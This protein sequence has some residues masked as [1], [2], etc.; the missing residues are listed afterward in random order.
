[1]S[2]DWF[3][4]RDHGEEKAVGHSEY[5]KEKIISQECRHSEISLAVQCLRLLHLPMQGVWLIPDQGAKIPHA[6]QTKKK[7]RERAREREKTWNRS[8]IV[9]NSIKALKMVHIKNEKKKH[10]PEF[11]TATPTH[12]VKPGASLHFLLLWHVLLRGHLLEGFIH[13]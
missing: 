5:W 13:P 3:L 9:T 7:K 1:M 11:K 6:L 4:L 12:H 10:K 2:K 8:N